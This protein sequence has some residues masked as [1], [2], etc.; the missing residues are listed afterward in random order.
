MTDLSAFLAYGVVVLV[1]VFVCEAIYAL[2][3][4]N[5]GLV[6]FELAFKVPGAD[7]STVWATYLDRRHAWN[8]VTE[9]LSYEVVSTAPY[10]VRSTARMRGTAGRPVTTEWQVDVLEPERVCRSKVLKVDGA[11]VP[12]P[13]QTSETFAVT[14]FAGGTEVKVEASIP[15]RGWLRVPLHRRYLGRIFEDLRMA[16]LRQAGVPFEAF[17]RR[18]WFWTVKR[19]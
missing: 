10:V 14:P 4:R 8:S 1:A 9:R 11:D 6:K 12:A 16:S 2:F 13:V 19:S 3:F 7:A 18:W 15:V 5:F 17:E